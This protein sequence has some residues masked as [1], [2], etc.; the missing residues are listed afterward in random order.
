MKN[1]SLWIFTRIEKIQN[2]SQN[3]GSCFCSHLSF[4]WIFSKLVKIQKYELKASTIVQFNERYEF[5][6]FYK[7]E[8]NPEWKSK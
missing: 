6:D 3:G 5:M 8:K 1:M 2:E 7:T 4:R